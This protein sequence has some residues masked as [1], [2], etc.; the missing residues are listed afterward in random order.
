MAII[1]PSTRRGFLTGVA[2]LF[3][4]P[5]IVSAQ[6]LMP[7]KVIPFDPY[8]LVRGR[9]LLTGEIVEAKLYEKAGDP[10]AF[11]SENFYRRLGHTTSLMSMSGLET[12]A[13][14]SR[15]DEKAMRMFTHEQPEAFRLHHESAPFAIQTTDRL[16][17]PDEIV[18]M[19]VPP[20]N[21]FFYANPNRKA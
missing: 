16:Y 19:A 11:L 3:A 2:S 21:D 15:A 14:E 9:D 4:A 7:I 6:N 18:Y 5:A 17:G 13:I 20:E 1:Q 12:A 8:M 10:F